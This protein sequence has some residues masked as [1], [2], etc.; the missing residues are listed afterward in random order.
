M[1]SSDAAN[2]GFR[3]S[4]Y[5]E[6]HL[7]RVKRM[8]EIQKPK[9]AKILA[10]IKLEREAIAATLA[11]AAAAT[12]EES[13]SS[14]SHTSLSR[15]QSYEMATSS[16]AGNTG[17][18]TL[19]ERKRAAPVDAS[20]VREAIKQR[21]TAEEMEM[22]FPSEHPTYLICLVRLML[23]PWNSHAAALAGHSKSARFMCACVLFATHSVVRVMDCLQIDYG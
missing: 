17:E 9:K 5:S 10:T 3:V 18:N 7:E 8:R 21:R 11:A 12:V 6:Q 19:M 2:R 23:V 16:S 20:A 1:G 22:A 14:A 13:R 15:S 4:D